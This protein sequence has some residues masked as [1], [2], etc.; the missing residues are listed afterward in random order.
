LGRWFDATHARRWVSI[1]RWRGQRT[2]AWIRGRWIV[3][4]PNLAEFILFE[5]TDKVHTGE[6][7]YQIRRDLEEGDHPPGGF[8][9]SLPADL[10]GKPHTCH[11]EAGDVYHNDHID[12]EEV[13][14]HSHEEDNPEDH[15]PMGSRQ[16]ARRGEV[17][18]AGV[19]VPAF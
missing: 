19:E 14:A 12:H 18:V 10:V 9:T 4:A 3:A 7:V 5:T 8:L 1:A 15:H 2:S 16:T 11:L 13:E 6:E 17:E